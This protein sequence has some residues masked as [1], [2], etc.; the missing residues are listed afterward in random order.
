MAEDKPVAETK[1]T[2]GPE[3]TVSSVFVNP[4]GSV[5]FDFFDFS[6]VAQE[7]FGNDIAITIIVPFTAR[8]SLLRALSLPPDT[9]ANAVVTACGGRFQHYFDVQPFL[10]E[11]EIPFDKK[12]DAWA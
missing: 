1:L 11:H 8:E 10:E 3:Q 2:G 4:D 9:D 6:P 5:H 7:H 12:F